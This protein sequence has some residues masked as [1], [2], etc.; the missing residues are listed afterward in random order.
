MAGIAVAAAACGVLCFIAVK[1]H[2]GKRTSRAL[3]TTY[4]EGMKACDADKM[5]S[6]TDSDAAGGDFVREYEITFA[7]YE[8]VGLEYDVDYELGD[9]YEADEKDIETVCNSIYYTTADEM[10]IEKGYIVPVT[11]TITLTAD[12]NS[13][14]YTLDIAVIC[15][16]KDGEWYLGGTVSGSDN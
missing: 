13:S 14:P 12:G 7:A 6:V 8:S 4:M 16:E 1:R 5:R 15:Y 10:G 3:V 9:V 2:G 11:G